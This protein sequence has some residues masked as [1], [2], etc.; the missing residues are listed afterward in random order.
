MT[1]P[2]DVYKSYIALKMHF[3][4]NYD[5]FKYN[6]KVKVDSAS[7]ETRKDKYFFYKLSKKRDWFNFL[8]SNMIDGRL[9]V[10]DMLSPAGE[11]SYADWA[12]R[13]QSL[14]YVF[15]NELDRLDDKFNNNFLVEDNQHPKALRLLLRKQISYETLIILNSLAGVFSHWD[16]KIPDD[17]MW[18]EVKSKAEKYKGF[19]SYDKD[20]MSKIVLSKFQG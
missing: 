19:L 15:E 4:T 20:K 2:F 18:K 16:K 3:T 14:S 7:F 12:K 10:G 1:T 17:V 6:G 13:T 9:W 5:Y 11:Q 8:L